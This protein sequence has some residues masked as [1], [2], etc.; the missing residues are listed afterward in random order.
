M[1]TVDE[2]GLTVNVPWRTSERYIARFLHDS[3]AW[4]LRKLEA[5]ESRRPKPRLWQDGE[6]LDYLGRQLRLV[7]GGDEYSL[8]QLQDGNV[9]ALSL[10][11]PHEPDKV[12]AAL[13]KWYRRHAQHYFR[14]RVE[15]YSAKLGVAAPRVF[16]S[17][18]R[19]RWGSCNVKREV[20]LSWRLMQAGPH[21]VDYVVVHELSHLK[22]MNHSVRFWRIVERLCPDYASARAE[23]DAMGQHFMAL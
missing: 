19:S 16:V 17:N 3:A 22:E 12:R 20:R 4:V 8:A 13:V 6:L 11:E 15:H 1:L 2:R 10:P 9:L 18:A 21:I 5:W 23:L 7:L 14:I